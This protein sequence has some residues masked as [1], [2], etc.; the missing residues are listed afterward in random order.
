MPGFSSED[1]S[2]IKPQEK[3]EKQEVKEGKSQVRDLF[4]Q[5]VLS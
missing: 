2:K 5:F 1:S 4:I 3:N